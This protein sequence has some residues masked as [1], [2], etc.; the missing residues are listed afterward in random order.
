MLVP[1]FLAS[2]ADEYVNESG[3]CEDC[4]EG[5]CTPQT[6]TQSISTPLLSILA[7]RHMVHHKLSILDGAQSN[8]RGKGGHAAAVP[9]LVALP[10]L[11]FV[12]LATFSSYPFP[13]DILSRLKAVGI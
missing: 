10:L 3:L 4:D 1:L 12:I 6:S 11:S 7:R 13:L 8:P 5:L 2:K 9:L